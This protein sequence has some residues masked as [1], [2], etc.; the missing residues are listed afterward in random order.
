[1]KKIYCLVAIPLPLYSEFTYYSTFNYIS[2]GCQVIVPFG[3]SNKEIKGW[4]TGFINAPPE[5]MVI[6]GVIDCQ[7]EVLF[8][9][10][11]LFIGKE[12]AQFYLCSLGEALDTMLPN[13]VKSINE[14]IVNVEDDVIQE[15]IVLNNEQQKIVDNIII[16]KNSWFYLYGVTGS[17]KS[18]I[19]LNV[20]QQFL[21]N[22]KSII[23]LV[24]E[25]SLSH[26]LLEKMKKKFGNKVAIFH[27][28]LTKKERLSQWRFIQNNEAMIVLGARSAIFCPVNN[29]GLIIIDEE[30]EGSYKSGNTPRY[31]AKQIAMIR[32]KYNKANLLLG[33]ATPSLESWQLIK[34]GV[35]KY[36][37]LK[38][39][40]NKKPLPYIEI[41]DMKKSKSIISKDLLKA[42]IDCHNN[43]GQTILF[44]NQ[45]GHSK[46]LICFSCGESFKC[47]NCS[48]NLVYHKNKN[49][50][51]CHH[52]GFQEEPKDKCPLCNNFDIGYVGFGTEQVE[53]FLRKTLPDCQVRR[54][55]AD[56]VSRKGVMKKV[57]ED[58]GKGEIDI[59]IGT[60]MVAKGLNFQGVKLVGVVMADVSLLLP[61]FRAA[62]KT[63]SLITQVAGRTGRFD[64]EGKVYIQTYQSNNSLIQL[65]KNYQL[66]KFY[67]EELSLRKEN[68]FPPYTRMIR[69]VFR[70]RIKKSVT[71]EADRWAN[72]LNNSNKWSC[73][74][75]ALCPL[76]KIANNFRIHILLTSLKFNY[77]HNYISYLFS[78]LSKVKD[79]YIEID[80]DPLNML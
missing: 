60:Q 21:N 65:V 54:V 41:I 10:E 70:G 48:V 42:I 69:L 6:K 80:I 19:F 78:N 75:P 66:E 9:E 52:C 59:L 55:D 1:M 14:D 3:K 63:F 71:Q 16:N 53:E 73:H 49:R 5:N 46:S 57:L 8:N 56:S 44:L 50:L 61:D 38:N 29:L 4:V 58:F 32:A 77:L 20:A 40:V 47:S 12:I 17:G 26:Q 33:S 67:D 64:N 79:V 23:Y 37:Y 74:G 2:I 28:H 11:L 13:A 76:E 24:P 22:N 34:K 35:F 27:S 30:H 45:R 18:E 51:V 7:K 31:H 68:K 39:R 36:L 25:I 62:E 43:R 72:H 15:N